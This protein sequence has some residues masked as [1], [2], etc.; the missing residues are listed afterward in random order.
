MIKDHQIATELEFKLANENNFTIDNRAIIH[1]TTKIGKNV[2]IG[3]WSVIGPN[4]EIGSGTE[5]AS[6][7]VIAGNTKIGKNNKI[8]QAASLGG[9]PQD[10]HY[11]GEETYLRIADNNIFREF[12]TVSRGSTGGQRVTRIGNN[13]CFLAYSHIAHDCQ[14]GSGTLFVNHAT[15][16]GH[17]IV[18]DYAS[19]G[20]FSAVHQFVRIGAYSFL[21]HA[22]Q[23][24]QDILPYM[25]VVGVR[26]TP[27]GL[28][29]VG[30]KRH[31]FSA[32][33]IA[34][35]KRAYHVIYR[36]GLKLRDVYL[37]LSK[38]VEETPEIKLILD[39]IDSSKRGIARKAFESMEKM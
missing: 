17:V 19:I 15:L 22:A 11:H 29:T 18:D 9:D 39:I 14:I 37:E 2:K 12:V 23:V 38:M 35:L 21:S 25:M 10:L 27:C 33:T 20:A 1:P 31:G 34:A 13:N 7:V 32:K 8:Y 28:N 3:P 36:R 5:I 26:G 16:A 24:P 4:V 6:H 30:L